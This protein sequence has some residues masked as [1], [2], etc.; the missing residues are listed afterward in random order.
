MAIMAEV[1]DSMPSP[2][3]SI[4]LGAPW[5]ACGD[6]EGQR[7][8][9]RV[10]E[11]AVPDAIE[12]TTGVYSDL[13]TLDGRAGRPRATPGG[14]AVDSV[15]AIVVEDSVRL[16]L[17]EIGQVPL[18]TAAEEIELAHADQR[19]LTLVRLTEATGSRDTL[20]LALALHQR[21]LVGWPVI[22]ALATAT[23][24][25]PFLTLPAPALLIALL[26]TGRLDPT[27]LAAVAD[28]CA[29]SPVEIE[30][31]L[32]ERLI[33][34]NVL[35]VLSPRLRS[36]LS[37]PGPLPGAV[38]VEAALAALGPAL[39]RRWQ[40]LIAAGEA[41]RARL[42]AANLRLVV[43][44]ARK[45]A[46]R[47]LPLLDL[48]QEGNLGL[49]RAVEKFEYLKGY[50]LSTY[51]TWWIRQAIAR[52]VAEQARPVRLPVH[53]HHTMGRVRRVSHT[54]AV[55]LGR[56]P[57]EAE[58]AAAAEITPD[59]VR[60]L[61][62]LGQDA[63]SLQAGIGDDEETDLG[64]LLSD[65]T[66]EA[67]VEVAAQGQLRGQVAALL[68]E[69]SERERAVLELR[70]GLRDG[71]ERTLDRVAAEFGVT[72]ERVRQIEVKALRKLR[73]PSRRQLLVDYLS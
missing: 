50:K 69:L 3:V 15:D 53:L 66:A 70:F 23:G 11:L 12:P 36:R 51:A 6:G 46:N 18:L 44:I 71:Q 73:Q 38:E 34:I 56:E 42:V 14:L 47:G 19:A 24:G 28:R 31:A 55:E 30:L 17:H 7:S 65:E 32:K 10:A 52:A 41:A 59:Q 20:A 26:P 63:V 33:E 4:E 5:H 29:L 67:P 72:R 1:F 45:H 13:A 48:V 68:A 16:Y 58:V 22:A 43:S 64:A 9:P 61:H 49:I 2:M 27:V 39:D 54:L 35:G 37:R 62:R 21:L 8:L 60:E 25:G 57:S 40:E